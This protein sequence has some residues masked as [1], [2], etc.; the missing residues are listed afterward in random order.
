MKRLPPLSGQI[1]HAVPVSEMSMALAPLGPA[2]QALTK[3]QKADA[4]LLTRYNGHD[5]SGGRSAIRVITA[6]VVGGLTGHTMFP[7]SAGGVCDL[8]LI[9]GRTGDVLWTNH[10]AGSTDRKRGQVARAGY[11]GPPT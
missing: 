1:S 11:Y 2:V 7:V 9:D 5:S 8:L 4:L 3:S 10:L 6:G